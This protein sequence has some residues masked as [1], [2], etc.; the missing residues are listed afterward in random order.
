[1][2]RVVRDCVRNS[3]KG[4]PE[5]CE[6]SDSL[7]SSSPTT[8]ALFGFLNFDL[9]KLQTQNKKNVISHSSVTGHVAP[10]ELDL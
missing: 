2:T 7:S 8:L 6:T 10:Q 1:M 4:D 5:S 9:R 3:L